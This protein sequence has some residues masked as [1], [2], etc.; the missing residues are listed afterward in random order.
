MEY[1]KKLEENKIKAEERTAKKRAKR[2][3]KKQKLRQKKKLKSNKTSS[4]TGSESSEESESENEHEE[5][6]NDGNSEGKSE[7]CLSADKE[8][9]AEKGENST[10]EVLQ[11]DERAGQNNAVS[12]EKIGSDVVNKN[13]IKD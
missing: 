12:E 10:A 2:L 9:A 4:D 5:T 11:K 7:S 1:Q 8:D 13:E 3:K 6:E